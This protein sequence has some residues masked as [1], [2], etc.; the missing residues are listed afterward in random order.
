MKLKLIP[1]LLILTLIF[2]GN[3]SAQ[4]GNKKQERRKK[5]EVRRVTFITEKLQL[6]VEEA[7][8]FWPLYNE[9]KTK[10]QK[11]NLVKREAMKNF[12]QNKET[13]TDTEIEKL[14]DEFIAAKL[15]E[16]QLRQEYHNK[17]KNTLPIKKVLKLYQAEEQFKT[18]LIREMKKKRGQK[19]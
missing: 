4:N 18:L 14:S 17:F 11:T 2:A 3:I 16:A 5:I 8:T 13:L 19:K 6:T 1:L 15:Q 7:Q 9:Y 12:R 10:R